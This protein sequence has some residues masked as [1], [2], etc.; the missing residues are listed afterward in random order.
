MNMLDLQPPIHNQVLLHAMLSSEHLM[1]GLPTLRHIHH[2]SL[3]VEM[4]L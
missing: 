3:G 4:I 1:L 2:Q